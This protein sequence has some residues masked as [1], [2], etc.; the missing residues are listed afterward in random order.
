[1]LDSVVLMKVKTERYRAANG[2]VSC[3]GD[4]DEGEICDFLEDGGE[5]GVPPFCRTCRV[6]LIECNA[7][8]GLVVIPCPECPLWFGPVE[9]ADV[10]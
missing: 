5:P 2:N 3:Q 8:E 10:S 9:V 7:P 1:M 4:L 6:D